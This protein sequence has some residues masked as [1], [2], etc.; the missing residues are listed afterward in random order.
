MSARGS[1]PVLGA[2]AALLARVALAG[3]PTP[4]GD[5]YAVAQRLVAAAGLREGD[6]VVISGNRRDAELLE[7]VAARVRALGA[8][9]IVTPDDERQSGQRFMTVPALYDSRTARSAMTTAE[10]VKMQIIVEFGENPAAFSHSPASPP[11]AVVK[12]GEPRGTTLYSRSVRQVY[13]GDNLH[14][15]RSTAEIYDKVPV[16]LAQRLW[17]TVALQ[18]AS[19]RSSAHVLRAT[20][21]RGKELQVRKAN[22]T[23]LTMRI[24]GRPVYA[25]DGAI[26][27][28]D[29]KIGGAPHSVWLPA[30]EV[31]LVPVPGSAEGTVV[32]ERQVF[33]GKDILGLTLSYKAGK[34]TSMTARSGLEPLKALYDASGP[35]KEALGVIDL[36]INPAVRG[37]RL[38]NFAPAGMVTLYLGNNQWAGGRNEASFGLASPLPGTTVTV[39][40]TPIVEAGELKF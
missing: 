20:L 25:S 6:L 24:E 27:R 10:T 1:L 18:P 17:E 37:G 4:S 14:P 28:P 11:E 40:G 33:Q 8:H 19:L 35:G 13:L 29:E 23:H 12:A 9:P 26:S 38:R 30:G 15:T 31:Y 16:D 5:P 2:L 39:D 7:L 34:L 3:G 32:V 36:V 21:V 22:G